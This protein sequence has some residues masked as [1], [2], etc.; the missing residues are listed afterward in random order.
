MNISLLSAVNYYGLI[1]ACGIVICVVGAYFAAKHRG[2]EGDIVIDI[3]VIC[4]PLAILGARIYYV[5]FDAIAGNHWTFS[6]FF[7]FSGEDGHFVGLE[8]LAIYGGLIGAVIGAVILWLWKNRKKNPENKRI[9][10]LQI[11]DLGFT[12]IILGQAVGRWGNFANQEAYG[13][14]ITNPA[15][16]FFPIGVFIEKESAW[17]YATFFYES[18]WNTIGFAILLYLYLGKYKSF[19]G[20]N[21]FAYCIYYGIG[22]AWI[23][24]LR[25]DSLWLVPPSGGF[26]G[27]RV[28]QLLSILLILFG[29][30]AIIFHIVRA[31]KA[32]KKTFI[33]VNRAKLCDEYYGYEKTKLAHP[34][35]DI[36]FFKDRNKQKKDN[37]IVDENGVA[38][39]LDDT[40]DNDGGIETP[41]E[42]PDEKIRATAQAES[43]EEY[44]DKWDD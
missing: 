4:L 1:I 19:D 17:H 9:T 27:I 36:T 41:R 15:L 13:G 18:L 37:V 16:Q 39:R 26:A 21:L 6:K 2:I 5:I 33:F 30:G 44:E 12:F 11:L 38:I 24:G 7:G 34:M 43:E 32:G 14:E 20:F 35:P 22:R 8:G 28:S 42:T 29:I 3:I 10:F 25:T 23:E 40:P 31:K